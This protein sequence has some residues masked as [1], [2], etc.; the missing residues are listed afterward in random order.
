[1]RIVVTARTTNVELMIVVRTKNVELEIDASWTPATDGAHR[2]EAGAPVSEPGTYKAVT[3][4]FR[5]WL[6]GKSPQNFLSCSLFAL[7]V[8]F[9]QPTG[10]PVQKP[11]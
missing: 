9:L 3:A 6:L 8:D 10:L 5:P 4:R 1:M 11:F 2:A 7:Q